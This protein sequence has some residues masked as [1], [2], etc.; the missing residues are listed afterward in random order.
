MFQEAHGTWISRRCLSLFNNSDGEFRRTEKIVQTR[1]R[2]LGASLTGAHAGA[3][4]L[5][6]IQ[7]HQPAHTGA[8]AESSGARR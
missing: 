8:K 1:Y 6:H 3:Q 2:D 4:A 5:K 7:R